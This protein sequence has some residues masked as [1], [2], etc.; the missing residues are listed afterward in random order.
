[1]VAAE[2]SAKI[3]SIASRVFEIEM[4]PLRARRDDVPA[5][6]ARFIEVLS[7]GAERGRVRLA[8]D[9]MRALMQYDWP[10]NVRELR[11][12]IEHALVTMAGDVVRAVDLPA[13]ISNVRKTPSAQVG[14]ERTRIEDAL[15]AAHNNRSE[16]ARQLGISRVTLWKK[17]RKLGLVTDDD[18]SE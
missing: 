10:G 9:A 17:M 18:A 14:D 12:A 16:A 7:R 3:S 11:N 15:K 8:G 1:M 6:A 2:R 13:E 4:P 5:L